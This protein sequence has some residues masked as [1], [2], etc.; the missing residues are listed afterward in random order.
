MPVI[1]H[2][3]NNVDVSGLDTSDA[4]AQPNSILE[5]YSAYVQGQK[6]TGNIKSKSS[7]TYIPSTEDQEIASGV[8][9]E[10]N[11]TIKGDANLISENIKAGITI[12][13]V[14]G[15]TNVVDTATAEDENSASANNVQ[16]GRVAFVNGAKIIGNVETLDTTEI[17]P[18][19]EDQVIATQSAKKFID[20][21]LTVKGDANL[22]P[23]HIK[24]GV[25]IFGVVGTYI[26]EET[27]SQSILLLDTNS[28]TS[29]QST[30]DAYSTSVYLYESN[31]QSDGY[32]SL[33]DMVTKWGGVDSQNNYIGGTDSKYG[34]YMSNW[35]ESGGMTEILFDTFID[36]PKTSTMLFTIN[37]YISSWMN[38]TPVISLVPVSG[39]SYDEQLSQAKSNAINKN[40]TKSIT[41][42][43][44]SGS[45]L[46]DVLAVME[47]VPAGTYGVHIGGH[48]KADNSGFTYNKIS[49]ICF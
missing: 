17:I 23:G 27:S 19:I 44:A 31:Y 6:V 35:T 33:S 48:N 37:A 32:I 15:D 24:E 47:S 2:F 26:G 41:V 38:Y 43:I 7:E 20:K 49:L 14:S 18:T 12:F 39:N 13:E 42:S 45:S 36:V 9:L 34:I 40:F 29:K 16:S 25:E 11:Q 21:G 4:T 10:G 1:L 28:Y 8:Y 5:G 22:L 3:P 30:L 46:S